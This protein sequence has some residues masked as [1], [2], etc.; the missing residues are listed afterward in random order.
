MLSIIVLF[1]QVLYMTSCT[2]EELTTEGALVPPTVIEDAS[3]PSI[4]I[5]G[6]LFHSQFFG[7]PSD[8]IIIVIHGGPG[9]DY[10]S[11]LN[12]RDLSADGFFVVFYDQR[13]S[14]LSQRFDADFYK[15][16]TVQ[17]FIDDLDGVIN[18]FRKSIDQKLIL[19]IMSHWIINSGFSLLRIILGIWGRHLSGDMVR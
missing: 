4:T 10:R 6:A 11:V 7:D 14:G 17:L 3:I 15:D 16:Q 8:P 9:A 5:N 13:G 12:F 18:H 19:V 2:T 1:S